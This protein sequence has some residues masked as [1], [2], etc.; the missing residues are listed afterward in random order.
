MVNTLTDHQTTTCAR[1]AMKM[2]QLGVSAKFL[3]PIVEGP[4]VSIYKF[5]PEG[6]TKVSQIEALSDD[7]AI[8][9]GVEDVLVKRM[10]G[11]VAVGIFVPNEDRK[12]VLWRDV[13]LVSVNDV[14]SSFNIPLLLGIDQLGQKV[15]EDL[16]LFPHLLIAGSTGSGKSTLLNSILATMVFNLPSTQLQLCLSD[17]KGVEFGHFIG[18]P[19]LLWNPATTV[20]QTL[21]QLDWLLEEMESRL[22]TFGKRGLRNILEYNKDRSDEKARLPYIVLVIDELADLLGNSGRASEKQRASIGKIASEKLSQLAQKA[23]ATG[24]H[25]IA[26]TQRP[27]VKLLEGNIKSNF[28]ARLSFRLPSHAD[29]T[30]VLSTGGAEHLLSRGDM[31]FINPSKAG[32]QRIHAPLT[33]NDDIK[34]AIDIAMRRGT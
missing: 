4:V 23:R 3:G 21:E 17:T 13:C 15:I 27:S 31:L 20:Y 25:I 12:W 5:T 18:A 28:P 6:S 7:F 29:S 22:K 9:L 26:G 32:M 34:A 2:V 16:T 10:P 8:A 33:S 11:E 30:T 24:I 14:N 19:H 1:L